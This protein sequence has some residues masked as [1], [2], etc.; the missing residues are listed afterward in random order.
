[1]NMSIMLKDLPT[2]DLPRERLLTYGAQN[3]SNEEL[4]SIILRTGTFNTSVK[5]LST[6]ILSQCGDITNLKYMTIKKMSEIKGLGTVKCATLLAALELGRRVYE[7]NKLTTKLRINNSQDAF[8]YFSRYI[9]D[10]KQENFLVIYLDN[11]KQYINYKILF[12]GTINQSLVHPREIFKN[13]FLESASAIVVMHNHPSGLVLPSGK[14]D[15]FTKALVEAGELMG[16][17]VLDHLVVGGGN[18]YSYIE[19]GRLRYE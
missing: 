5:D 16:I 11:Q 12:K 3:L 18:Y 13:A 8:K 14:D 9:I 19:E 4:I 6:M 7:E 10:D 17:K 1:M 15:E 2:E